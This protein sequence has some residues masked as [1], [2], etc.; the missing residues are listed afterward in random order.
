MRVMLF[1]WEA[2]KWF[3]LGRQEQF[4][5]MA[6]VNDNTGEFLRATNKQNN[7]EPSRRLSFWEK[8]ILQ[9]RICYSFSKILK[10]PPKRK[11][12]FQLSLLC[13]VIAYYVVFQHDLQC[14][15]WIISCIQKSVPI[16][17]SATINISL[18]IFVAIH[19]ILWILLY[20]VWMV[21]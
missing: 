11:F 17:S 2:G 19:Y 13:C 6:L 7:P 1:V 20:V 18:E 9:F 16:F 8:Y 21:L 4:G 10:M 15:I 3:N 5:H 12:S 14:S